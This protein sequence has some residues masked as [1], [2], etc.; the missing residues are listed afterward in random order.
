MLKKKPYLLSARKKARYF[1]EERTLRVIC[2]LY[3][4]KTVIVWMRCAK[5]RFLWSAHTKAYVNDK[6]SDL[7]KQ[8]AK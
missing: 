7:T 3:T 6:K 1:D 5:R 8:V 4:Y 2:I